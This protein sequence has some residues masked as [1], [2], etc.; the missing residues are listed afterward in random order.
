MKGFGIIEPTVR[1]GWIEKEAPKAGLFEAVLE[2][3]AL[4]PCT[5]DVDTAMEN[6][7]IAPNRILGHEGVGRV[8]E[9]GAGVTDLQVGDVVAVPA[10]TPVWRN[11]DIQDGIHQHSGGPLGGRYLSSRWDGMF[12]EY[13]KVP[14]ADLNLAKI[15]EGV[16]LEAAALVGDMVTTGFHG[17]ELANVKYG[18]RVAVIGIGPVGLMSVAG[19]ALRGAAEIFAVGSRPIT[20]QLAKEFGADDTVD[21]REAPFAQQLMELTGGRQFDCVIIAGGEPTVFNDALSICRD[22]FDAPF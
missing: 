1:V 14:D 18:D 12:G 11:L 4:C 2:P 22:G 21:Y 3:V 17:A 20:R 5:S 10:V 16:S 8:V 15:P 19:A 7:N 6:P 13:F 9:V